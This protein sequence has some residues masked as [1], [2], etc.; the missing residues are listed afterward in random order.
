[1]M[2]FVEGHAAFARTS[3]SSSGRHSRICCVRAPAAFAFVLETM[4]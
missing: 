1:V 2:N 4:R 3:T